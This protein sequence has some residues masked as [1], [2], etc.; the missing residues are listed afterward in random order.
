MLFQPNG[1]EN[2]RAKIAQS[3]REKRC[4]VVEHPCG[5]NRA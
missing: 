4:G 3:S 1:R 5:S 2:L